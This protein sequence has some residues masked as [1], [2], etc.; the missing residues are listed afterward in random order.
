MRRLPP[1]CRRASAASGSARAV[2]A[3]TSWPAPTRC[4]VD[5]DVWAA[6]AEARWQPVARLSFTGGARASRITRHSL[7]A[8]QGQ[9]S[10]RPAFDDDTVVAVN[11][12]VTAVW[13]LVPE[14]GTSGTSTK[15]HAAA[16]TGIKPPDA[17]DIAFTDNS[18]LKP[19]RSTSLEAGVTQTFASGAVH[20]DGTWFHNRYDDLIVSVGR[21]SSS[22]RFTTDNIA[23]ARAR[24]AEL[25]LT[26]RPEARLTARATYTFLD[27]EILA[28]DGANG[29]AP[30][31]FAVGD[32]LLRRPRHQGSVDVAW[33]TSRLQAFATAAM[34]GTTLDVEPNFG[35]FG[36]LFENDGHTVVTV[37]GAW[38]IIPQLTAF[39]R[40]VNALRRRLRRHARIPGTGP[41]GLRGAPDCCTPLSSASPTT[42]PGRCS[43]ASR[44]TCRRGP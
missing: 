21:F 24:G 12:K 13:S 41:H 27:S 9:F 4:P 2:A 5:R 37:G 17:F 10:S 3:P 40:V 36:G 16:G 28:V 7:A 22:S 11:P 38:T 18:G 32:R 29:Q 42:R 8:H 30:S 35:T 34:R 6:F 19:E 39:A 25:A 1:A 33:G 23:N 44:S 26:V 20:V 15:L 43:R 14:G 31:P